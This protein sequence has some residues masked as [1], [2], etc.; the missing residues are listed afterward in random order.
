[1]EIGVLKEIKVQEHRVALT[2]AGTRPLVEAG[3]RVRVETGAG[4]GSGFSDSEYRAAGADMVSAEQAWQSNLVLKVKEPL[5]SEYARLGRQI[6]FTYFHLAGV[7]RSLT[8]ALLARGT[9]AVAYETVEDAAGKLPLLAPMSAVAG[10]MAVT[11]GNQYLAKVNGGKGVLLGRVFGARSGNVVVLGDGVV[12]QHAAR[13][14]DALGAEVHVAGLHPSRAA[15]LERATSADVR[16][17]LSE[18]AAISDHLSN[19][20]VVVGAVLLRGSRAPRIVTEA[21]VRAM[22]PGSVIVDVSIDQGGCV[23]TSHPT[24]H[25]DP[26]FV[27]HGVTHY[28]VANMPGAYPRT[29]TIALT[30]A[31]LPYVLRLAED[32]VEALR[33]DAGFAKGL[34]TFGGRVTSEAVASA[35]GLTGSYSS[36]AAL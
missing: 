17:F 13:A 33:R 31:T 24:S 29:S 30:E 22:Q 35:L 36:F 11:I 6:V 16:F 12:G 25:A 2:P 7:E 18:P 8:E 20:D 14:A 27:V 9:T 15:E 21:M 34:S 5:P 10:N 1:M 28:C 19:A 4:L 23:E 32:G 3:H 26:V